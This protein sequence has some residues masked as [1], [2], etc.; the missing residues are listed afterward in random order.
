MDEVVT[1][2]HATL[3]SLF[4]LSAILPLWRQNVRC[5]SEWLLAMLVFSRAS[6][7]LEC[8]WPKSYGD[9]CRDAAYEIA[10][11][12]SRAATPSLAFID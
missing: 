9:F 1:W 3:L 7:A 11:Y 8:A 2:L 6:P 4:T 5:A 10:Q 12:A